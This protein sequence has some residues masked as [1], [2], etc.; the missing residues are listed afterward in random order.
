MT[1]IVLGS[2]VFGFRFFRSR[3]TKTCYSVY[4]PIYGRKGV[5]IN[6]IGRY[7]RVLAQFCMFLLGYDDFYCFGVSRFRFSFFQWMTF[8]ILPAM[9]AN[10][11]T[12]EVFAV[13]MCSR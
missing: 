8:S 11:F 10:I 12:F 3:R 9:H 6:T 1:F 13:D 2:R 7:C 4:Y 5:S